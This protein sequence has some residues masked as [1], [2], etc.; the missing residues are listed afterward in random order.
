ML[1]FIY[2]IILIVYLVTKIETFLALQ[3]IWGNIYIILVYES[4][5]LQVYEFILAVDL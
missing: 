5:S 4:T 1:F 3:R 2:I